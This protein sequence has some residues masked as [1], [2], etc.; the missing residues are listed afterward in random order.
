MH[1]PAD[2]PELVGKENEHYSTLKDLY[3]YSCGEQ[4]DEKALAEGLKETINDWDMMMGGRSNLPIVIKPYLDAISKGNRDKARNLYFFLSPAF[5]YIH[6]LYEMRRKA[7]RI[8]VTWGGIFSERIVENLLRAIDRR[9][10][11]KVW[12]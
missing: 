4:K 9:N 7:W 8:A 12:E 11:S 5:F 6:I 3:A 1:W 10:S 2:I